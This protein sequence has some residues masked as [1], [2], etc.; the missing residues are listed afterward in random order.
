MTFDFALPAVRGGVEREALLDLAAG[1]E[2]RRV[3]GRGDELGAGEVE[4]ALAWALG[5]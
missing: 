5:R 1:A 4:V 3:F 2:T